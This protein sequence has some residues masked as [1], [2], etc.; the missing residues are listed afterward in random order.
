MSWN[1]SKPVI[2]KIDGSRPFKWGTTC[3][4]RTTK[5]TKSYPKC[6][7][8]KWQVWTFLTL[9]SAIVATSRNVWAWKILLSGISESDYAELPF[10]EMWVREFYVQTWLWNIVNL[11]TFCEQTWLCFSICRIFRILH[12]HTATVDWPVSPPSVRSERNVT[13]RDRLTPFVHV[14]GVA[15][16]QC[17]DLSIKKFWCP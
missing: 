2:I 9:C 5:T 1:W 13:Q 12:I 10:P 15:P 6:W 8:F 7:P 4:N 14:C 11:R 16:P 17:I 3:P